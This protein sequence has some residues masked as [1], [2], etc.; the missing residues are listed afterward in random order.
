MTQAIYSFSEKPRASFLKVCHVPYY[1]RDLGE[2]GG[3]Q[4]VKVL[5]KRNYTNVYSLV[6]SGQ[7]PSSEEVRLQEE[8]FKN[9]MFTHSC[10]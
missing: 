6:K 5:D 2:K 9:V 1:S 8:T 4:E 7:I 3:V 10:Q